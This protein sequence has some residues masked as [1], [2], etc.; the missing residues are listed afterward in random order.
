MTPQILEALKK[1][2]KLGYHTHVFHTSMEMRDFVLSS[3]PEEASVGFG[4]SITVDT[5]LM[6][7]DLLKERGNTVYYHG[8][9]P[10][11]EKFSMMR[12]ANSADVYLMSS[13]AVTYEGRILNVD[14]IGN[15]LAALTLG[16]DTVYIL[17]GVNKFVED[18]EAAIKRMREIA[19]PKN[20]ARLGRKTPCVVTGKCEDCN[21]PERICKA[22]LWLERV[23]TG[24]REFHICVANESL[25]L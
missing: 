16:P 2:E 9:C 10:M 19:A 3:I 25:G 14:G 4:G 6:L 12:K 7:Y 22:T 23:P 1:M 5:N 21:S 20:A 17:L 18:D 11:E 8:R 24:G 13:N 15:R